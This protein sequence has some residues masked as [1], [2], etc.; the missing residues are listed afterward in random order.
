[1]LAA[2]KT[3]HVKE[4]LQNVFGLLNSNANKA[5]PIGA[6]NAAETP[7][8]APIAPNFLFSRSFLK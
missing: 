8:A 1:M 3:F 2:K 5:P 6:P 7:A 4:K